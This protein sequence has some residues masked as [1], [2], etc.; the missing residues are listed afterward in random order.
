MKELELR[1]PYRLQEIIEIVSKNIAN[2]GFTDSNYCLYSNEGTAQ[3]NQLC[4]LELYPTIDDN[5]ELL[6]MRLNLLD[7]ALPHRRNIP[8]CSSGMR[9]L[10]RKKNFSFK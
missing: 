3:L 2:N 5:D 10:Y 6:Y 8:S 9:Y 7:I 1:K 4:Y